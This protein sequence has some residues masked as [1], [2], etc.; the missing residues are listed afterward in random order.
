MPSLPMAGALWDLNAVE[1]HT[2]IDFN[3]VGDGQGS[4]Y[5]LLMCV[6]WFSDDAIDMVAELDQ[7]Y[8]FDSAKLYVGRA[9][10][11]ILVIYLNDQDELNDADFGTIL[12]S[13]PFVV[14]FAPTNA[15][16]SGLGKLWMASSEGS[17]QA[18]WR[19]L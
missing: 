13:F 10:T 16:D 2:S 5:K 7:V 17:D 4:A 6:S 1:H 8:N 11:P 15:L 19:L 9:G 3:F 12:T 14:P 18:A